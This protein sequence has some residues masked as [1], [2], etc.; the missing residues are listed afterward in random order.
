MSETDA[1]IVGDSRLAGF[2]HYSSNTDLQLQFVIRRGAQVADLV[3]PTLQTVR[4]VHKIGVLVVKIS[5]GINNFTKFISHR[6]GRELTYAGITADNVFSQLHDFKRKI[7]EIRPDALVGF[8]T[9]PTLSFAKNI[10]SR[11]ESRKLVKS[12]FTEADIKEVQQSLDEQIQL[13]NIKLKFENSVRQAG[14]K[15]GCRTVS[16]HSYITK[17]SKR[18]RNK[19]AR[20]SRTVIRNNFSKLYDGLHAVSDLKRRWFQDLVACITAERK[21][22]I[23]DK[24]QTIQVAI[25]GNTSSTTEESDTSEQ[26]QDCH[27]DFKRR[28][29]D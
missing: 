9:V 29:T 15:K 13:L 2:Q 22:T 1:I 23:Y 18:K 27:W 3:H 11:I 4:N 8:V 17:C 6:D 16:W 7:K 25:S 21:Y 14:H 12:K 19:L 20:R 5:C 10:K 24:S 28:K 26:S